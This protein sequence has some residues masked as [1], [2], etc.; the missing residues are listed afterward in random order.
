VQ[1][2]LRGFTNAFVSVIIGL[3]GGRTF[4]EN[5]VQA[6]TVDRDTPVAAVWL[7]DWV[8]SRSA[9]WGQA[10]WWNWE[11]DSALYPDWNGMV[12]AFKSRGI[13]VMN[14]I[15]P[16]MVDAANKVRNL[17]A[18]ALENGYNVLN[19]DGSLYLSYLN[20][21]MLDLT[22]PAAREF[23]KE[24]IKSNM[25]QSGVAGWMCDFGEALPLDAQ[26]HDGSSAA[27]Y[28]NRY[29]YEWAQLNHDAIADMNLVDEVVPFVRSSFTRSPGNIRLMWLGDQL[30]TWDAYDGIKTAVLGML[31]TGLFCVSCLFSP[32][33]LKSLSER[34]CSSCSTAKTLAIHSRAMHS[35][36]TVAEALP[37]DVARAS[38]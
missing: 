27:A 18:E 7:Q 11:S 12:A 21:S 31:T 10:L 34:R 20:A 16:H 17:F 32:P 19:A 29:P 1:D 23:Y 13:P 24:V 6:L 35:N 25:L 33:A 15:N 22:N 9:P 30:T 28:H 36:I 4:V 3:Q 26:L 8:G 14:Y 2:V 5:I 38:S 37:L